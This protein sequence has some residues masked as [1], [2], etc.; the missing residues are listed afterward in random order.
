MNALLLVVEDEPVL[1]ISLVRG[2]SKL[3]GVTAVGAGTIAE[4]LEVIDNEPPQLIVSDIDLP[5]GSG[6]ELISVLDRKS[7]K[8]PVL[9]AS[10]YVAKF[11]GD[12]PSRSN[13][14]VLEKPVPLAEIRKRVTEHLIVASGSEAEGAPF[15]ATDYMQLACMCRKSV[16]IIV[17]KGVQEVGHVLIRDG[18]LWEAVKGDLRGE[19]ALRGL[20]FETDAQVSCVGIR[21]P[22][23]ERT[24]YQSWESILL[25]A[26]RVHDE[27][28]APPKAEFSDEGPVTIELEAV[29]E[30]DM[31]DMASQRPPAGPPDRTPTIEFD[32]VK[33]ERRLREY[34]ES[35]YPPRNVD[36][37][38]ETAP[39]GSSYVQI[40][41]KELYEKGVEAL[42]DRDY[43]RA[44][45]AFEECSS[46][47][48]TDPR[49]IA[50]L[51][52]L[53]DMGYTTG[54]D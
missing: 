36:S 12:I 41:F 33:R 1:R 2:L 37:E 28:Q 46:L 47:I 52:R 20:I 3:K 30:A 38:S 22:D 42:L 15:D 21:R 23:T 19:E 18:E 45:E 17:R 8:I 48:P 14:S 51:K 43:R 10:A 6:L 26:A 7:L 27:S 9:Y 29:Q 54:E 11:R 49:V 34:E 53:R 13:I 44:L 4:A 35:Q 25:E 31:E 16:E 50:N 32:Y 40:Q 24:I 5:D 39:A